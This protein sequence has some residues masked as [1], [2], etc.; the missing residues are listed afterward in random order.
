M[1]DNLREEEHEESLNLSLQSIDQDVFLVNDDDSSI[2]SPG[3]SCAFATLSSSPGVVLKA[4]VLKPSP[5]AP[6]ILKKPVKMLN[7]DPVR[8]GSDHFFYRTQGSESLSL[9]H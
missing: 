5:S 9:T 6:V 2:S 8:R 1:P 3:V 7:G 4:P